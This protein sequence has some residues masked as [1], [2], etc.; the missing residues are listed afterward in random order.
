MTT[1]RSMAQVL[2]DADATVRSGGRYGATVWPTGFTPLDGYLGGG[3]RDGELTLLGGA[4]GLGKTMF[5][6]QVARNMALA[7]RPVLYVCFEHSEMQLLE[8]LIALEAGLA[9]GI[10][11]I[12]LSQVRATALDD[13]S[14]AED[15]GARLGDGAGGRKA[16]A[17]VS[18]YADRLRV[19]CTSGS[20]TTLADLAEWLGAT[21]PDSRPA[22]FVDYLQKVR[23][24]EH[25]PDVDDRV[26]VVVE[27]LK[28]LALAANV[29]V[30]AVVAADKEGI[31]AGRT[32]LRHLRGSTSLAYEA[33]VALLLNNKFDIVAR[34]HL[35]YDLGAAERHHELAICSIEKNRGGLDGIDLQ[36]RKHFD[37]GRYDPQG[38]LVSEQLLDDRLFVE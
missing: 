4:Q 5:A 6:L 17:S 23:V 18:D 3:L 9:L 32:R 30:F 11:G 8:R 22:L 15:L 14:V 28:D 34:H 12:A 36:F 26:A 31:G 25:V 1:P 38:S 20:R 21:E 35:V 16:V 10:R 2:R 29:P 33:D 24:P 7:G 37:Q 19:V 13:R 27:G